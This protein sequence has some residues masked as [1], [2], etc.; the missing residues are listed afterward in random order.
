MAEQSELRSLE[1]V[2]AVLGPEHP[3]TSAVQTRLAEVYR[4]Q[5]RYAEAEPFYDH[6]LA[7]DERALGPE[8]PDVARVLPYFGTLCADQERY[9]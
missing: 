3:H 8:H 9:A 6:S 5:T 1:I 7:I 4:A 2:Q